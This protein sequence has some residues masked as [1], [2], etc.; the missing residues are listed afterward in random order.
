M[1]KSVQKAMQILSVLSE[2]Q[3]RPVTLAHIAQATELNKSTC[4]H[5]L[6]TLCADGYVEHISHSTGYRIGPALHCLTGYGKYDDEFVSLCRPVMRYVYKNTQSAVILAVMQS[7]KKFIID[8]IDTQNKI[9]ENDFDVCVDD[10]YRTA[11]GRVMLANMSPGELKKVYQKYGPPSKE[12]W[13]GIHSLEQLQQA[14]SSFGK[15]DI[16]ETVQ[17]PKPDETYVVGL[18]KAI[19]KGS[20]CM[21]ALGVALTYTKE[22]YLQ[23]QEQKADIYKILAKAVAE[24][25]RRLRL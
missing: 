5:I 24:I 14:L 11:T 10:I 15:R 16:Y 13:A 4:V 3:N 12:H 9:F 23:Y 21:G 17:G 19:F 6:E 7:E 20:S 22:E 2:G 8:H 1:I 18:G 25:N